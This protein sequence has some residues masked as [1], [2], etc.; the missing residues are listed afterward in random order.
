MGSAMTE[1]FWIEVGSLGVFGSAQ[2][3]LKVSSV[4]C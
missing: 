3:R 4:G 1:E 2:Q